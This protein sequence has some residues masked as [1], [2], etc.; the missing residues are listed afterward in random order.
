MTIDDAIKILQVAKWSAPLDYQLA[1]DIAIKALDKKRKNIYKK[2]GKKMTTE[3]IITKKW[4]KI[5]EFPNYSISN[6]GEIRNDVTGKYV[7]CRLIN[8]GI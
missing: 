6:I 8:R 1:F 5:K 4:A 2:A 7:N 3:D